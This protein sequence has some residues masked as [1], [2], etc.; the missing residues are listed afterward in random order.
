MLNN[1]EPGSHIYKISYPGIRINQ[2]DEVLDIEILP[3]PEEIEGVILHIGTND[4]STTRVNKTIQEIMQDYANLLWKLETIYQESHIAR[5][6]CIPRLDEFAERAQ[7]L[8]SKI[9]SYKSWDTEEPAKI[10]KWDRW[11]LGSEQEKWFHSDGLHLSNEGVERFSMVIN[12]IA[13]RMLEKPRYE[14]RAAIDHDLKNEWIAGRKEALGGQTIRHRRTNYPPIEEC[15]P[16]VIKQLGQ[17]DLSKYDRSN[18]EDGFEDYRQNKEQGGY[19]NELPR[20]I[21]VQKNQWSAKKV[22]SVPYSKN[23]SSRNQGQ[24][25]IYPSVTVSSWTENQVRQHTPQLPVYTPISKTAA[26]DPN[27]LR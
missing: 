14:N 7:E 19:P 8:N 6:L 9:I 1:I 2:L 13:E 10:L 22:N 12:E 26:K 25:K 16:P 3:S 21:P 20:Y 5:S 27:R 15:I 18:N 17:F 11:F 4:A 23:F 24:K